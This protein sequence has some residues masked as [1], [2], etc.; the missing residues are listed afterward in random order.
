MG[1]A[2]AITVA[3]TMVASTTLLPALLGF[4]QR[5]VEM[6]RWRGLVAAA[7]VA[8]ALLGA[9]LGIPV[10]LGA[11]PLAI[12]VLVAGSF[13]PALRREVPRRTPKPAR[14]R[15]RLNSSH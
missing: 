10:L 9:G 5:N 11:I 8:V 14:K 12:V 3:V 1:V 15:K 4:S 13:V 2:A 7:L 6:T